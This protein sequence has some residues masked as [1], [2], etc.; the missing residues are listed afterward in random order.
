[1][2]GKDV[3]A[4]VRQEVKDIR[5]QQLVDLR[6]FHKAWL[7]QDSEPY[8][9]VEELWVRYVHWVLTAR[10]APP[11]ELL[12]FR[13]HRLV[14]VMAPRSGT[15]STHD[16]PWRLCAA[17][18]QEAWPRLLAGTSRLRFMLKVEIV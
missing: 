15:P 5:H 4:D 8:A 13:Q 3:F 14:R 11:L 17:A 9:T 16:H 1:M 2:T 18:V 7:A 10:A 6:D 12:P